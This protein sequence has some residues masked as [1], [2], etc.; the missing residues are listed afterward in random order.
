MF[1]DLEDEFKQIEPVKVTPE[2]LSK[3]ESEEDFTG[4]AVDLLVEVGSHLCVAGSIL[5]GDTKC[6]SRDQAIVGGN[7]VRLF[8]LI[9]ALLDQTCQRRR[10]TSIIYSRLAF[11]T[12]VNIRYLIANASP[13][14]FESYIRYSLK[15]ERK[16]YDNV[17]ENIQARGGEILPIEKR[18][19]HSIERTAKAS[20]VDIAEVSSSY[21]K[22]WGDKNLFER[23]ETVGLA[24]AY[25]P[26]VGG[27]SHSVHGNWMDLLEYHLKGTEYGFEPQFEWR[28]PRPQVLFMLALLTVETVQEYLV[29]IGGEEVGCIAEKELVDLSLRVTQSD[30]AHER[31]LSQ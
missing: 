16:L 24:G 1:P 13:E 8:K 4:L 21:P 14:L 20:R 9:S 29:F 10:E 5:P 12:I 26:A 25:R 18:M 19:L 23:A 15:H 31:F 30:Q 2:I 22:N 28:R 27:G 17:N 3:F 6:W 11:E 7:V